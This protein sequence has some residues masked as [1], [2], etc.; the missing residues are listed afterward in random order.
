MNFKDLV[1]KRYSVRQYKDVPVEREKLDMVLEAGRMAPSAVNYQPWQFI[2]VRDPEILAK[3]HGCYSR[4]WFKAAPV[5]IVV[6]GDHSEGWHR[7]SDGKD[8]TDIDVAIAV[9]H[10]TL[11]AVELGLGTCWVCN[12]NPFLSKDVLNLPDH[13]EAIAMLPIGYPSDNDVLSS[14][15]KSRKPL[16]QILHWDQFKA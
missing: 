7:T 5:V 12:F 16:S 15:S 13:L 1:L 3:L 9:D 8:H 4:E 14:K 10:M 2:V 11:Q 6:C